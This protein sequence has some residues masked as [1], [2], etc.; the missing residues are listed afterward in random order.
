MV[1]DQDAEI[2][3]SAKEHDDSMLV[4]LISNVRKDLK[5]GAK[6]R[7]ELY[8]TTPSRTPK[9]YLEVEFHLL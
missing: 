3:C 9:A 2:S 8:E 5:F 4:A 6:D 1:F 7:G